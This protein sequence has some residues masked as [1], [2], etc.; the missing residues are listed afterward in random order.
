MIR[1]FHILRFIALALWAIGDWLNRICY[2]VI[3]KA[4]KAREA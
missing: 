2:R 4:I 1:F 3:R